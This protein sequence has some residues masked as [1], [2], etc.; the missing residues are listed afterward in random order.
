MT[1]AFIGAL[2]IDPLCGHHRPSRD[3]KEGVGL[4]RLDADA[5]AHRRDGDGSCRH[6]RSLSCFAARSTS[7]WK[8]VSA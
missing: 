4:A 7:D 2:P 5:L 1:I 8:A 6:P 3:V